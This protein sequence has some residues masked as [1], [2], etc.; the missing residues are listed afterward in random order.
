MPELEITWQR[1]VDDSGDTCPRCGSTGDA[2][3]RAATRLEQSLAPLGISVQVV[4]RELTE[5][6]FR[7]DPAESNR[8]WIAGRPLEEWLDAQAGTSPCCDQCGD[9]PCRTVEVDGV[10]LEAI[11]PEVIVRAGLLAAADVLRVAASGQG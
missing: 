1:L 9:D 3:A 11:P 6:Q 8:I 5:E 2:V 10:T 4:V 7:A